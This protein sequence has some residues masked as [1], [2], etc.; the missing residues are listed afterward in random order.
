MQESK[1]VTSIRRRASVFATAKRFLVGSVVALFCVTL[2]RF[3]LTPQLRESMLSPLTS[4]LR[5]SPLSSISAFLCSLMTSSHS[6]SLHPRI[7]NLQIHSHDQLLASF[8]AAVPSLS[9]FLHKG[10]TGK[11]AVVG[12]SEEYTGAPSFAAI[13]ALRSGADLCHVFCP[14]AAASAIKAYSPD[15]IVHPLF[16]SSNPAISSS[17]SPSSAPPVAASY[18]PIETVLQWSDRLSSMVLGP[19]LG[20]A[21]EAVE[22]AKEVMALA[23]ERKM[24]LI[25]DG[26]ALWVVSLDPS[27][28][29]DHPSAILTPNH[30][31][32][33]RI[34]ADVTPHLLSSPSLLS[35]GGEEDV[36]VEQVVALSRALGNVT[37]L[38]KGAV[39]IISDGNSLALCRLEGAPRR[40]GG[41]GDL[42]AGALGTFAAWTTTP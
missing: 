25:V 11:V 38:K 28:V 27:L 34:Y 26:D 15:L 1:R 39:D 7:P 30:V 6:P 41:Q 40:C 10:Q 22:L 18:S 31:E 17:S 13:T 42:T 19:G 24:P 21:P 4:T 20:R 2:L 37:I 3:L 9:P 23:R 12:G 14:A 16:C 35:S 5:L 29:Q 8:R 36:A 32:F 33:L